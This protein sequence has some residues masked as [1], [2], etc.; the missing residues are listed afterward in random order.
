MHNNKF[1]IITYTDN[2]P[3]RLDKLI[4]KH[5]KNLT[6]SL[7][8]KMIRKKQILH[9][10]AKTES[11]AKIF[12]NDTIQ[13]LKS[14]YTLNLQNDIE[15]ENVLDYIALQIGAQLINYIIY[16]NNFCFVTNKRSNLSSQLG[17]KVNVSIACAIKQLNYLIDKKIT[18]PNDIKEKFSYILKYLEDEQV[19]QN[20]INQK[21]CFKI[22]HRLDSNTTGCFIIAKSHAATIFLSKYFQ[23]RLTDK[24]YLAITKR[25]VNN[26]VSVKT[27]SNYTSNLANDYEITEIAPILLN[28]QC[29]NIDSI[30][31][32]NTNNNTNINFNYNTT[33]DLNVNS[34][35]DYSLNLNN[36]KINTISSNLCIA[37]LITGKK[38]QIRRHLSLLNSPIL[39]DDKYIDYSNFH[40][41]KL[42]I[43][44]K[45]HN[46]Y[47]DNI[48]I[49]SLIQNVIIRQINNLL[50]IIDDNINLEYQQKNANALE[51]K[52]YFD[53]VQ[54]D[55]LKNNNITKDKLCANE[56]FK[57]QFLNNNILKN[58]KDT[59]LNNLLNKQLKENK[60]G[61]YID[62]QNKTII[63]AKLHINFLNILL[64][65]L[66]IQLSKEIANNK[67]N[68]DVSLIMQNNFQIMLH[69]YMFILPKEAD[70]FKFI[71]NLLLR[72]DK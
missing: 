33:K 5:F 34:N 45:K 43:Q 57:N 20:N 46:W 51:N 16:E 31:N 42:Y 68:D 41:E 18:I 50:N 53:K 25:N 22:V 72:K 71:S 66:N 44:N 21:L 64:S 6:Q 52:L 54:K 67:F 55:E 35:N 61:F 9:N 60:S 23:D 37:K 1:N 17:S 24:Y 59:T 48:N 2:I 13:I 4:R 65:N 8:E 49:E 30:G 15:Q 36:K 32:C 47:T 10:N 3:V 40:N 19:K 26:N 27:I 62:M 14:N 12:F 58:K 56:I 11:K 7:I 28:N 63:F 69:S 70:Y 38:H 29:I 39:F